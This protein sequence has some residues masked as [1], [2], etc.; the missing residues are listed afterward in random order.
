MSR[1]VA[2]VAAA[3]V[4]LLTACNV[5]FVDNPPMYGF[6]TASAG[7]EQLVP[8][9]RDVPPTLD[10]RLHADSAFREQDVKAT[11]DSKPVTLAVSGADLVG[12]TAP[13]P[14]ASKHHLDVSVAGRAQGISVDFTVI[15][16]TG[17]MFA[18]HVDPGD[19]LVVDGVFDDAPTQSA[20]AAAL[21][22]AQ[23]TWRDARHVRMHWTAK[24]PSAVDLPAGLQT[25]RGS[26]LA[27]A[28]HVDLTGIT[29][30][31]LR[32]ATVPGPPAV[33]GVNVVAFV[34]DSAASNTSLA[35]H[36]SVLNWVSPTGWVAQSDG[37]IQGTS[38]PTAVARAKSVRLP[39]WPTLQ[40]NFQDQ[41]GTSSLLHN[42]SA[43]SSLIDTVVQS[44]SDHGYS[45]VNVDFESMAPSDKDAFTAFIKMLAS[46]LHSHNA[47]LAVDVVPHDSAGINDFS[48]AYDVPTLGAAADL[49]DIMCYD[50]HGEGSSPGPV[51]GL[52][53]DIA[54]LASTLQGLTPSHTL[55]GIPLYGRTWTNG[56]GASA[57]YP[58]V[59]TE[60]GAAG[61]RVDYDFGAATPY[62]VSADGS[63]VTYFDDADSLARKI[64]LAHQNGLA[65]I[66]AWRLGFEDPN[67]WT[68]FG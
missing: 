58:E 66:A 30:G 42:A 13:L 20:I 19:G 38:D 50:Q 44:V 12:S 21:P 61:A 25:A 67:F 68:L 29:A 57:S 28:L 33:A 22:A 62:I 60:A 32:R 54:Q 63:T 65:G 49:V 26:H 47:Q 2:L 27:A 10:L 56:S 15:A 6:I 45:G 1:R 4:L 52:D 35:H 40:N 41:S 36:Q 51:A 17:A 43:I 59:L 8:G 3:A 11:V 31:S 39:V 7:G 24:P 9:I 34:V 46:A 14:L 64:A 5:P 23:L 37:T 48:A 53:W 16:P 18:A 55:L